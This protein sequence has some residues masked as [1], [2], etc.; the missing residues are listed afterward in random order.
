MPDWPDPSTLQYAYTDY[1]TEYTA[2]GPLDSSSPHLLISSGHADKAFRRGEQE[3]LQ[4]SAELLRCKP[5]IQGQI[6]VHALFTNILVVDMLFHTGFATPMQAVA[7]VCSSG[8]RGLGPAG[9][10]TDYLTVDRQRLFSQQWIGRLMLNMHA[11][12]P[13]SP[14]HLQHN[15]SCVGLAGR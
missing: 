12:L 13:K 1:C 14:R 8:C 2:S 9:P 4:T 6:P 5:L 11:V 7:T 10:I 15:L 3:G